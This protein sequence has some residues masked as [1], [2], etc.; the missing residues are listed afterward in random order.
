[1]QSDCK[2]F[3]YENILQEGY[4]IEKDGETP[5]AACYEKAAKLVDKLLE[6][7]KKINRSFAASENPEIRLYNVIPFIGRR[8]TGKTSAM[9]TFRNML[10]PQEDSDKNSGLRKQL[11]EQYVSIADHTFISLRFINAEFLLESED[12]IEIILAEMQNCLT[13]TVQ[14]NGRLRMQE[15]PLR[16]LYW[17][18]DKILK[19]LRLL[20]SGSIKPI[21]AG[22]S[23]LR[24]LKELAGSHSVELEFRELVK[25]YL[26]FFSYGTNRCCLVVVIDDVDLYSPDGRVSQKNAYD[27]LKKIYEFLM[28]PGI[29]VLMS[30]DEDKIKSACKWY[31]ESRNMPEKEMTQQFLQKMMPTY[32]RIYLPDYENIDLAGAN[33][34]RNILNIRLSTEKQ[35]ELFGKRAAS[36]TVCFGSKELILLLIA[37]RTGIYF[38][39]A[40][41]KKHFLEERNLRELHDFLNIIIALDQTSVNTKSDKEI[42][43]G[44]RLL[45]KQYLYDSFASR[46]LTSDEKQLFKTWTTYPA[47]RRS[48]EILK[49]VRRRIADIKGMEK[50]Q[51]Q[52]MAHYSYGELARSI[53]YSSRRVY[54]PPEKAFQRAPFSKELVYCILFMY[55]ILLNDLYADYLSTISKGEKNRPKEEFLKLIGS[56]VAGHWANDMFPTTILGS[57]TA[58]RGTPF[59]IGSVDIPEL[60]TVWRILLVDNKGNTLKKALKSSETL[61][62]FLEDVI[63]RVEWS[64]MFFTRIRYHGNYDTA[65]DEYNFEIKTLETSGTTEYLVLKPISYTSG[66]ITAC[67]NILNFCVNSFRWN[68][69]FPS[70]HKALKDALKRQIIVQALDNRIGEFG[71]VFDEAAQH[72]LF[73]EYRRWSTKTDGMALPIQ[74]FDMCYN[75]L[76][77]IADTEQNGMAEETLQFPRIGDAEKPADKA[78]EIKCKKLCMEYYRLLLENIK[79]ALAVQDDSYRLNGKFTKAFETCPFVHAVFAD[80]PAEEESENSWVA[81]EMFRLFSGVAIVAENAAQTEKIVLI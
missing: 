40:G 23:A 59:K 65:P 4:V 52:E 35:R 11:M 41:E 46:M 39:M 29:I 14:K 9:F 7:N 33:D 78:E 26:D 58:K 57:V 31:F 74:N 10:S 68:S 70:L 20:R 79:K 63:R 81:E 36:H 45:I 53:Y 2:A 38:D 66:K 48:R 54:S 8:G 49:E 22:E 43:A 24:V 67:F 13:E 17:K 28:V 1:M 61:K 12:I 47:L 62:C 37:E 64:G 72:T 34:T 60:S 25:D 42:M 80:F 18:F 50:T 27:L 3:Y 32:Q 16:Q 76:K 71:A 73:S 21:E 15:E 77:R 44:N 30:Y 19:H 51:D 75:I 6:E 56:S 55:S 69:Y 5:F